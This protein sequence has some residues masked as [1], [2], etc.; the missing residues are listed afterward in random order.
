MIHKISFAAPF[1]IQLMLKG[2]RFQNADCWCGHKGLNRKRLNAA[3]DIGG[4]VEKGLGGFNT[5]TEIDNPC[6]C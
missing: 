4:R 6:S 3:T 5:D 2:F 1:Q